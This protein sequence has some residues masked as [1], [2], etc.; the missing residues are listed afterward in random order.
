MTR[1]LRNDPA[2]LVGL[3]VFVDG[4]AGDFGLAAIERPWD[5]CGSSH[6]GSRPL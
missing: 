6:S 4:T 2:R 5:K 3:F 1:G